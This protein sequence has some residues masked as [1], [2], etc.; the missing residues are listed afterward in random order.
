[1]KYKN[2]P[3]KPLGGGEMLHF[4][5]Q[6]WIMAENLREMLYFGQDFKKVIR[7]APQPPG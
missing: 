2:Y 1:M 5:Q 6:L 4:V 7:A 3:V